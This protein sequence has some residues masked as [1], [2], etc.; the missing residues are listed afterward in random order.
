MPSDMVTMDGYD[1]D[2]CINLSFETPGQNIKS[3]SCQ[4]SKTGYSLPMI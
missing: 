1:I 4:Y 2:T 3:C